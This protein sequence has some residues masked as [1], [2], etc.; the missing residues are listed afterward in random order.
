MVW[1]HHILPIVL[2]WILCKLLRFAEQLL[3]VCIFSFL[4]LNNSKKIFLQ[5]RSIV[6]R[7]ATPC[8]RIPISWGVQNKLQNN[9][10]SSTGALMF[11][12]LALQCLR[13]EWFYMWNL[14][15]AF[16]CICI[17]FVIQTISWLGLILVT[18][19][20][21]SLVYNFNND[22]DNNLIITVLYEP[23]LAVIRSHCFIVN[24]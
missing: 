7:F 13:T 4:E 2:L 14:I 24:L 23:L 16:F 18:F 6:E 21:I 20:I 22:N 10:S 9:G 1:R 3:W 8:Q 11:S 5:E 17:P 12:L 15:Y 19:Q